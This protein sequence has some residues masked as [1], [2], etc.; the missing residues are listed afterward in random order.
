MPFT[1][2]ND[3]EGQMVV[4][5]ADFARGHWLILLHAH[6]GQQRAARRCCHN[7]QGIASPM[8]ITKPAASDHRDRPYPSRENCLQGEPGKC[9]ARM[10]KRCA[11]SCVET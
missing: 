10:P 8:Y 7:N 9:V 3:L 2:G 4:V 6:G 11:C 5:A 1:A